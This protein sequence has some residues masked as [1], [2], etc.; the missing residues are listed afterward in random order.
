MFG[1]RIR[2][3]CEKRTTSTFWHWKWEAIYPEDV[4]RG[5]RKAVTTLLQVEEWV[6]L[7]IFRPDTVV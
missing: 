6:P 3:G 4:E 5:A 2:R 1:Q 7:R